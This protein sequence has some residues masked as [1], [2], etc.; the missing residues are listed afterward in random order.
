MKPSTEGE[1]V[2][3]KDENGGDKELDDDTCIYVMK[4]LIEEEHIR[5]FAEWLFIYL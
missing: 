5:K 1:K 2:I 3:E 4:C